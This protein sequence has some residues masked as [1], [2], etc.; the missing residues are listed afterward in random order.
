MLRSQHQRNQLADY[1]RS[2]NAR[3]MDE[4]ASEYDAEMSKNRVGLLLFSPA[5]RP[6]WSFNVI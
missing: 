6:S 1:Y 3:L 2:E 5:W 4:R